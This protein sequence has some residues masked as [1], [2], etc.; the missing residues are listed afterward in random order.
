MRP[1]GRRNVRLTSARH[2]HQPEPHVGGLD[3]AQVVL[4]IV[5]WTE[6][7]V[8]IVGACCIGPA[9]RR[10]SAHAASSIRLRQ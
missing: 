1:A 4:N 5:L 6:G 10:S 8:L 2:L 9:S 3:L 7:I